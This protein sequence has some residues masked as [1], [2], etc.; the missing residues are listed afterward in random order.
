MKNDEIR[1]YLELSDESI[2]S[3]IGIH[4]TNSRSIKEKRSY[5][6]FAFSSSS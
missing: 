4:L 1:K 5:F 3:S 2:Y 6:K